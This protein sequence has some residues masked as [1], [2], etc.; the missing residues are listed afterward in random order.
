MSFPLHFG[1]AAFPTDLLEGALVLP[2]RKTQAGCFKNL[3]GNS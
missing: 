2:K 1:P 3:Q